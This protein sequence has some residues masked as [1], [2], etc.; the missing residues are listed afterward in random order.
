MG[1][2]QEG[3]ENYILRS[4]NHEM[5][6]QQIKNSTFFIFDDKR[7]FINETES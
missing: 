4:V 1:K 2:N 6:R 3:C 7:C 5:C